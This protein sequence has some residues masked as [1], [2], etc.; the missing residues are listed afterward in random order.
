MEKKF[1]T[2]ISNKKIQ[3]FIFF[4]IIVMLSVSIHSESSGYN[5]RMSLSGQIGAIIPIVLLAFIPY[6]IIKL[7][8]GIYMK[9]RNGNFVWASNKLLYIIPFLIWSVIM[10]VIYFELYSGYSWTELFL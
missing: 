7:F 8:Y 5:N 6:W 3:N 9:V 4:S 2:L 10:F 1:F